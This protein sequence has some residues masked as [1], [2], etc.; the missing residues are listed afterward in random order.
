[1]SYHRIGYVHRG[2]RALEGRK[3]QS[4]RDRG[5]SGGGSWLQ[6]GRRRH[7]GGKGVAIMRRGRAGGIRYL[8]GHSYG[9]GA[10]GGTRSMC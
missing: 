4:D 10:H 5:V 3:G 6:G 9:R 7:Q 8:W 1:M 2:G